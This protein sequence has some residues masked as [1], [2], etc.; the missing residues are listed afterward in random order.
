M[1]ASNLFK[2]EDERDLKKILKES[3]GSV[4]FVD[5]WAEW[6]EPC[7]SMNEVF[8]TLAETHS[9]CKFVM[10][11]AEKFADISE[12][13]QIEAVPVFLVL[14]LNESK[15]SDPIECI[16][17][18][19]GANAPALSDV[20]EKYAKT[21]A[22]SIPSSIYSK[23]PN[24]DLN[25]RLRLLLDS[26]PVMLFMKG[27]P[28]QPRCGFSRQMV[29]ILN[30]NNISF[31]SFNILADEEVRQGLKEYS[32]WPTY[33]QLYFNGELVG[34]LDLVKE[35]ISSGEFLNLAPKQ[36]SLD[37]RL[38]E[39]T[40]KANVM[41]FMKGEPRAPR[42]G[43]S[44]QLVEI[45]EGKYIKFDSF[46]ILSDEEVRHG[47]KTYADWPTYPMLFFKGEL[48]GGLDVIKEIVSTGEFDEKLASEKKAEQTKT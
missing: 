38:K 11:E 4:V 12:A 18:I 19:S 25:T 9:N 2:L 16:E 43:F 28:N 20:V 45:L 22:A 8:Q 24:I 40:T 34:G 3:K 10:I 7:K 13:F 39:L 37:E 35:L 33:P 47:L 41:L 48:I 27:T 21:S 31:S 26:S 5:F 46:D 36:K 17:R 44:R 6:A 30:K 32:N 1:A 23:Q 42:C 14:K 29:E 15:K